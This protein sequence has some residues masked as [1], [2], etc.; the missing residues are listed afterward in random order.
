MAKAPTRSVLSKGKQLKVMDVD[1]V[2]DSGLGDIHGDGN[3]FAK[4][5]IGV[6]QNAIPLFDTIPEGTGVTLM[7]CSVSLDDKR[8]VKINMQE[9][10]ARILSGGP[11]AQELTAFDS[12][13]AAS[14]SSLT[15]VWQSEPPDVEGEARNTCAAA[16][17]A[18]VPSPWQDD[19]TGKGT[20]FQVNRCFFE[21]A[22]GVG[23]IHTKD[24]GRL[25]VGRAI[26]RDGT[27]GVEV[28]VMGTAVPDMFGFN[29]AEEVEN[30][31]TE[32]TLQVIKHRV[33]V[34]GVA[35]SEDGVSKY[36]IATITKWVPSET[37]PVTASAHAA[38]LGLA[39]VQGGIVLP[40]PL[41]AIM[42]CPFLGM[43][44]RRS[45]GQKIG[46]H[47]LLVMVDGT[48]ESEVKELKSDDKTVYFVESPSVKCALAS[49]MTFSNMK[50]VSLRGYCNMKTMLQYRLDEE[51]A[52]ALVSSISVK[53][54]RVYLTVEQMQKFGPGSKEVMIAAMRKEFAV[55]MGEGALATEE[56]GRKCRKIEREPTTPTRGL[57]Q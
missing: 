27:G 7:G 37:H 40:V 17:L 50:T 30:A 44:V 34:R 24:G 31:L 15:A 1:V 25:Y 38:M 10:A 35:R 56:T 11:R 4:C 32:T 42:K 51:T 2:D 46:A 36:L 20:I 6:W 18:H 57:P 3:K 22:T 19:A 39:T 54:G 52:M 55:G 53:D 8:Q 26:L 48:T 29:T 21:A 16:L 47:R 49:P 12:D 13:S 43:A 28:S 23:D 41:G 14:F 33:N 45:D 9:G 5:T